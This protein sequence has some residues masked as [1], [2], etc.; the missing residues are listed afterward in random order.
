[1]TVKLDV[2]HQRF[3]RYYALFTLPQVWT[4]IE[5]MGETWSYH[6]QRMGSYAILT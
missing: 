3:H 4:M 6:R 5:I 2:F 1:M